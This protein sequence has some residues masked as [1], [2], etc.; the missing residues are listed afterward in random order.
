LEV[1]LNKSE[2]IG[3]LAKALNKMQ[4]TMAGVKKDSVNP[5]FKS[6][7][8]DLTSCWESIRKPLTDNGLSIV[9]N[10]EQGIDGAA[11]TTTLLHTSGQWISGTISGNPS[12]ND[13]QGVGSAI[14]YF[15]RYGLMA[16]VGLCPED[17]DGNSASQSEAKSLT[18]D[19]L[20]AKMKTATNVNELENRAKKYRP[21]YDL[22]TPEN[23]V[24]VRTAKDMRKTELK[25][26]K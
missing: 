19:E 8:A 17:D 16:I 18:V 22:L 9:Q 12:K 24:R 20:I 1:K 5:F 4:S 23:Q 6:N 15:R 7:Y 11:I 26:A 14:T 13:P 21:D 2:E 3:E 25:E 10:G